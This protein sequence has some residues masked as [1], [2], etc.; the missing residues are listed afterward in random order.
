MAT[1]VFAVFL[2]AISTTTNVLAELQGD[3]GLLDRLAE[4]YRENLA[5]IKA[6][7]GSAQL[8]KRYS[9]TGN[10]ESK[11][12]LTEWT[13]EFACSPDEARNGNYRYGID[14][15]KSVSISDGVEAPRL[16]LERRSGIHNNGVFSELVY[17]TDVDSAARR[18]HIYNEKPME[19]GFHYGAFEPL[20]FFSLMGSW[21][22]QYFEWVSK[23]FDNEKLSGSVVKDGNIVTFAEKAE[24]ITIKRLMDLGQGGN[25][26]EYVVAE[27]MEEWQKNT[28]L[29]WTWAQTNG[30]WVPKKM[31]YKDVT[32]GDG[33]SEDI[34]M[35]V[36]WTSNIANE[37]LADDEFELVQL[38]LRRGDRVEDHSTGEKYI[39]E[40]NLF[41]PAPG[42][43][44]IQPRA[45]WSRSL[46]ALNIM[47]II[48]FSYVIWKRRNAIRG[49]KTKVADSGVRLD[50][51]PQ[52]RG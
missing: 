34:Q 36:N 7:K 19:A 28:T 5:S 12:W 1:R 21:P 49:V 6:W 52:P 33:T 3:R 42:A 15:N 50:S 18:A 46:I 11:Y 29:K 38:G 43:A 13:V 10:G 32:I 25:C 30:C 26:V 2:I 39:V 17:L 8:S 4:S 35:T 20:Y 22:D 23:N 47:V 31:T 41:P 48:I 27:T 45:G 9:T 44:D 24:G 14:I 37:P 51:S 16:R 40:G